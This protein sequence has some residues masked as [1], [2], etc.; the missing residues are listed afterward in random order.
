MPGLENVFVFD[1]K[2]EN[3]DRTVEAVEG[4]AR[5][6]VRLRFT[7]RRNQ[8]QTNKRDSLVKCS[9]KAAWPSMLQV[10]PQLKRTS[11][12]RLAVQLVGRPWIRV[13]LGLGLGLG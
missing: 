7:S 4:S 5:V 2:S 3:R 9:G 8:S 12:G 10:S 6:R 1:S 11:G 13:R